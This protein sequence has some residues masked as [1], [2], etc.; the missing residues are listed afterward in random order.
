[1]IRNKNIKRRVTKIEGYQMDKITIN[2]KTDALII[3]DVQNDFCPGGS[4]GVA[5]GDEVIPVLNAL[6]PHFEHVY[7]TQDWHP[8]NHMSFKQR[9][10]I[11]PPHCVAGTR[12]A[13]LHPELRADRAIHIKKGTNPDKEAYSGFQRTDLAQRLKN[14]GIERLF[15]GGLA[16]D[17]CVKNTVMD[18]LRNGFE[19]VLIDDAVRGVNINPGD[20]A[21]AIDEMHRAGAFVSRFGEIIEA[22]PRPLSS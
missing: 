13:E 1:V 20:S 21:A 22:A 3:V 11:W 14:A 7:T 19:V 8:S 10:G 6:I 2:R 15:I 12:G 5:R 18:A 16:T 17:Y 4:L 9:G